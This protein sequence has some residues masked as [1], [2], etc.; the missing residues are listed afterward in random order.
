MNPLEFSAVRRAYESGADV[1]QG[2][3]LTL[4]AGQVVGLLGRN[5]AGKT[6]LIH[7]AMGMLEPHGGQVRLFGQDPRLFPVEVR[8]RIGYVA[9]DQVLP[10]F[11][12]VRAVLDLHRGLFP[13]WDDNYAAELVQRFSLPLDA[14]IRALSKG[15]ARQVALVCAVAHRPELLILDEPAG[16]LDPSARREFL[17]T[18]L[19]LLN[20]S[21][22][23]ILFSSHHMGDVERLAE[24][25]L[26][27]HEG[28]VLLDRSLDELR[29]DCCLALVP[30][31]AGLDADALR[32]LDG[33]LGV[34]A[35]PGAQHAVF[36]AAPEAC[37]TLLAPHAAGPVRCNPVALE[38]LFVELTGGDA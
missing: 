23:T 12:K 24:R 1:L 31:D 38:E 37:Q 36:A 10:S 3:D 22:S 34:R 20:E 30:E 7:L 29:E 8:R 32:A 18:S 21:G 13:S 14:K 4:E 26:L 19:Q 15:Q 9:E 2:V 11:L 5:G 33:C 25:V 28:R 35:R 16:G 27:L 6:T 17:E